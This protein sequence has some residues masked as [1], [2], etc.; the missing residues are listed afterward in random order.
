MLYTV[1]TNSYKEFT[2]KYFGLINS[3]E[4]DYEIENIETHKLRFAYSQD[5]RNYS[6][7]SN[8]IDFKNSILGLDGELFFKIEIDVKKLENLG[9]TFFGFDVIINGEK[10]N[11]KSIVNVRILKDS[12]ILI[13]NDKA[14]LYNPYRLSENQKVL[15]NKMSRSMSNIFGHEV[16]WFKTTHDMDNASITFKEYNFGVAK[17]AKNI[18]IVVKN[19]YIPDN[20]ARFSE[21]DMDFQDEMEI[22]IDKE[23]FKEVFGDEIPNSDD[24]FYFPLTQRMYTINTPYNEKNFMQNDPFWKMT[25]VKYE[26]K[27]SVKMDDFVSDEIDSVIDFVHN[28]ELDAYEDEKLD[29]IG[30]GIITESD[31]DNNISECFMS[32]QGNQVFRYYYNFTDMENNEIAKTYELKGIK[33]EFTFLGWFNINKNSKKLISIDSVIKVNVTNNVFELI[34]DTD[35][36]VIPTKIVT[37]SIEAF[38]DEWFGIVVSHSSKIGNKSTILS[39]VDCNMKVLE[40]IDVQNGLAITPEKLTIFGNTNF[41]N[42]R[43]NKRRL[44]KNPPLSFKDKLIESEPTHKENFVI[45]NAV[46]SLSEPIEFDGN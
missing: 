33:D 45:D 1:S 13:T 37:T 16:M 11:K 19:N 15:Q 7:W 31:D 24:F 32:Y 8:E 9:K 35:D 29:A 27:S 25:C 20:K 23:L 14:N 17:Q 2:F 40:A 44:T 10:L 26:Q 18:K 46:P 34:V 5:G 36:F 6:E 42:I 30:D 28:F 12:N 41:A 4:F 43:V 38:Y 21:W 22:H 39:I 3:F